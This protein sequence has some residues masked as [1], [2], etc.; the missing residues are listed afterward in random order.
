[1]SEAC[2]L[3]LTFA[4]SATGLVIAQAFSGGEQ[5]TMRGGQ[6]VR[7]ES[8]SPADATFQDDLLLKHTTVEASTMS[9]PLRVLL[10]HKDD[11]ETLTII[12]DVKYALGMQCMLQVPTESRAVAACIPDAQDGDIVDP[13]QVMICHQHTFFDNLIRIMQRAT[14]RVSI[15]SQVQWWEGSTGKV[16]RNS[17]LLGSSENAAWTLSTRPSV[18][19]DQ[20]H[21]HVLQ[22]NRE[23]VDTD[24]LRGHLINQEALLVTG[25]ELQSPLFDARDRNR[26]HDIVPRSESKTQLVFNSSTSSYIHVSSRWLC[27]PQILMQLVCNWAL[28]QVVLKSMCNKLYQESGPYKGSPF[29][30]AAA[31][32]GT[33]HASDMTI[34]DFCD[35]AQGRRVPLEVQ[36]VIDAHHASC[37][38][39][40][41]RYVS[42]NLLP[43][44]DGN[45]ATGNIEF[46]VDQSSHNMG[47]ISALADA[48]VCLVRA[49]IHENACIRML[50]SNSLPLGLYKVAT[51]E[52]TTSLGVSSESLNDLTEAFFRWVE[53]FG[54][55]V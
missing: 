36:N 25:L 48:L 38:A 32:L 23:S 1:M 3:V 9:V 37:T 12:D 42:L 39:A 41:H 5:G 49:S 2:A 16:N 17:H 45:T 27:D 21:S 47:T 22:N 6:A 10:S 13:Q 31:E 7:H 53:P 14:R 55:R 8:Q 40:S 35:I 34:A 28:F 11:V 46:C 52:E 43:M 44:L 29:W 24:A 19:I 54:V 30:C 26:L 20:A 15:T 51:T 18:Q 33:I 4:C 50:Q